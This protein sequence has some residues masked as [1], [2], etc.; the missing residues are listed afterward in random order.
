VFGLIG[1]G[2]TDREIGGRLFLAQKTAKHDAT[3][4]LH[5]RHVRSR[6]EAAVFVAEHEAAV[7]A[8]ASG[9]RDPDKES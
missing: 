6:T 2:F 7:R 3:V 1:E 8:Q 5:K 4:V 9:P